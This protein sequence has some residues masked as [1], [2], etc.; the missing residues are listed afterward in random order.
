MTRYLLDAN[1]VLRFLLDDHPTL[2]ARAAT[3]FARAAA[4]EC[5]LV[6]PSVI[7]AECVWVL[8]SFYDETHADIARTLSSFVTRPGISA[9]DS[10]LVVDA[11]ERMGRTRLDYV[12]CYLAARG[13]RTGEAVASFDEDFRNDD[14]VRWAPD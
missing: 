9:D 8:R 7:V 6:L 1:L 10:A 11:L 14:I 5:T 12:D 13:A 4:G 3:L 2:S